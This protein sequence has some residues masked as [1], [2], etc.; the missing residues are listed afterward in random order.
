MSS[1]GVGKQPSIQATLPYTSQSPAQSEVK[2]KT[3]VKDDDL[4]S[5]NHKLDMLLEKMTI[6]SQLTTE[7]NLPE[8]VESL[9]IIKKASDIAGIY[10]S[11]IS[12]FQGNG[13]QGGVVRCDVCFD[14]ECDLDPSLA[15]KDPFFLGHTNA[16]SYGGKS[17]ALGIIVLKEKMLNYIEGHH[18][19]WYRFKIT[20]LDH[21]SCTSSK[22][23]GSQHLQGVIAKKRRDK[24]DKTILNVVSN[25]LKAALTIVKIKSAAL[26]YEDLIGLLHS[27]GSNVGNLGHSRAQV[28]PMLMVF[29][30]YV[31]KKLNALLNQLLPSTGLPPH[32][33]TASDKSTP[34]RTTNHAVMVVLMIDGEKKAIPIAV[35]PV[36]DFESSQVIGGTA[37][38]LAEQVISSLRKTVKMTEKSMT[39]LMSHQADG[40]Y[41]ARDFIQGM[42][43]RIYGASEWTIGVDKF[44]VVPWDAAYRMDLCMSDMRVKEENGEVLRR[45]IQR[46]NKFH[47]MF[48]RGRGF[49]ENKGFTEER[50]SS[51][52]FQPHHTQL[53]GSHQVHSRP[54]KTCIKTTRDLQKHTKECEK[55][56]TRKK[57]PDI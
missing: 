31:L 6:S 51:A 32:L 9:N 18:Q 21:V 35:P 3:N 19:D 38:H 10:G 23:G 36:Y 48:G 22:H 12:F 25:Q 37:S 27:T 7:E 26:H 44:F 29:Q 55:L 1:E 39:Y 50:E 28:N 20:L 43:E 56:Q 5:I 52:H 47:S 49:L 33:S 54:C 46:M 57:K 30:A 11:G 4:Y 34:I 8:A 15:S 14:T 41:Q 40:Q 42:K 17:L 16:A 53:H 2:K 13:N 24:K 45:L